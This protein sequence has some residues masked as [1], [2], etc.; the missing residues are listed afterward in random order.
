VEYPNIAHV[1]IEVKS[2]HRVVAVVG[3]DYLL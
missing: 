3:R 1:V 2:Y